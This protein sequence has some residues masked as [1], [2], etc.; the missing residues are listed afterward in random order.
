[1]SAVFRHAIRYGW[2]GQH[3]N[4]IALARVSSMWP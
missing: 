3:E 4:P 1:M 2:L